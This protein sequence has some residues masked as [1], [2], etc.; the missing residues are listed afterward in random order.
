M[1]SASK[2]R[3]VAAI[4]DAAVDCGGWNN[5]LTALADVAGYW[6]TSLEIFDRKSGAQRGYAPL[7]GPEFLRSYIDYWH[8]HYR[9]WGRTDGFPVGRI[10][11]SPDIMDADAIVRSAFYHEWVVPQGGGGDGRY[12]NLVKNDAATVMLAGFNS[13]SEP[14]FSAEQERWFAFAVP[15]FVRAVGIQS[16][17]RMAEADQSAVTI[18]TPPEGF[19]VVDWTGRILATHEL[20]E[21]RLRSA[22]LLDPFGARVRIDTVQRSTGGN[23][24]GPFLD[25]AEMIGAAQSTHRTRDGATLRVEVIP[26]RPGPGVDDRWFAVDQPAAL[27]HVFA[28][29]EEMRRRARRVLDSCGLTPAE[30]TVAIETA[31][32]DGRAAVASRLGISDA[33]VRSHL[34]TIFEKLGIHRQ[35]ELTRIVAEG[36][37]PLIE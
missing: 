16:R 22:G 12:A 33:T 9:I 11:S 8:T 32:G 6:A 35:A 26:I 13:L 20:T 36:S 29:E 4:Y 5:A 14:T 17:L 34:S 19:V 25:G 31:I 15:H 2:D 3:L 30:V 27:V 28:P 18:G 37:A 1:D 10:V 21:R 7:I 24:F 23:A